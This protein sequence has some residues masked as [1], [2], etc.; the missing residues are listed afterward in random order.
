M[1]VGAENPSTSSGGAK[2]PIVLL[3]GSVAFGEV[4]RRW[5]GWSRNG[6]GGEQAG[7]RGDEQGKVAFHKMEMLKRSIG[8]ILCRMAAEPGKSRT[9]A[10]GMPRRSFWDFFLRMKDNRE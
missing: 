8:T 1:A 10:R 7:G 5:R 2:C 3:A 6:A 4:G 9:M